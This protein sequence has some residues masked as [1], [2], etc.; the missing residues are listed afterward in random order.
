MKHNVGEIGEHSWGGT[1]VLF[2]GS[3]SERCINGRL[4]MKHL[5]FCLICGFV[6]C[7]ACPQLC[8]L[9]GLLLKAVVI[10]IYIYI[11]QELI[12]HC[13]VL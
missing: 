13:N 10:Y 8:S 11:E 7:K 12:N 2:N 6:H 1:K 5:Q 9:S 4:V 3:Q